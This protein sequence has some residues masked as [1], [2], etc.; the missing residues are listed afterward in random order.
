MFLQLF[1][2][3]IDSSPL[4]DFWTTCY[5]YKE[6]ID[7]FKLFQSICM[8]CFKNLNIYTIF[9]ILFI[10]LFCSFCIFIYYV[11]ILIYSKL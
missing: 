8:S 11:I 10:Y 7:I 4:D 5:Y 2:N 6:N 9:H 1:E 3:Y